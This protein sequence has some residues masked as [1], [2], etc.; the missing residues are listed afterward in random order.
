M[1]PLVMLAGIVA[2]L[3]IAGEAQAAEQSASS[4]AATKAGS[5]PGVVVEA[6]PKR[7]AIPAKKKAALDAEAAKR[8]RWQSYRAT[9]APTPARTAGVSAEARAEN[10]PGLRSRA[11]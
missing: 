8:K 5:V 3:V 7:S 9:T 1:R 6:P 10:Y 4:P 2:L 11:H